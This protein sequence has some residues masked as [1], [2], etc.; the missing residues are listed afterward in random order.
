[1]QD[2][3]LFASGAQFD[4]WQ[5]SN[6]E[7]CTKGSWALG[8]EDWPT[9]EVESALFGALVGDGRVSGDIAR[10]AGYQGAERYVWCCG[11]VDWTEAWKHECLAT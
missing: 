6:C 9:C 2:V 8:P 4:D 11:E 10:R 5:A 7:R 3:Y 1:M